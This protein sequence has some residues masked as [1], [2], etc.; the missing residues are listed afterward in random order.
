MK[1]YQNFRARII[2]VL[3]GAINF[4]PYYLQRRPS[5]FL[6]TPQYYSSEK[7]IIIHLQ[8]SVLQPKKAEVAP[9]ARERVIGNF[10]KK[11]KKINEM[12]PPLSTAHVR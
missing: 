7:L 3:F 5:N 11:L 12:I 10:C 6:D 1:K 9:L 8:Y 2:T 4:S